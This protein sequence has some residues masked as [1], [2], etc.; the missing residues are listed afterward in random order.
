MGDLSKVSAVTPTRHSRAGGNPYTPPFGLSAPTVPMDFRLRGNDGLVRGGGGVCL[1]VERRRIDPLSVPS[2]RRKP[3][4][5]DGDSTG[6][7]PSPWTPT[8]VGVTGRVVSL[9]LWP[10]LAGVAAA[11]AIPAPVVPAQAGIYKH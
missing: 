5:M 8:F 10:P 3:E 4:S 7:E 11:F 1:R 6:R 9:R 2:F